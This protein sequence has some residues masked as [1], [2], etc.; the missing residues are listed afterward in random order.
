MAHDRT[1]TYSQLSAASVRRLVA[2]HYGLREPLSCKFY[3]L[4]LHDNYLVE[5]GGGKFIL[6]L[7]RNHWRSSEEI[8]F[9]LDLLA[10]LQERN[11]PIAAALRTVE[12][13]LAFRVESPEGERMAALFFYADG[14]SPA[15]SISPREGALLGRAIAQVHQLT[16]TFFTSY[17]RLALDLPY[18]LDASIDAVV[19]FI[20]SDARSYLYDLQEQLGAVLPGLPKEAGVYGICI[21]DVNPTNFHINPDD[22]ITLFDFDQCGYG[23]RAFEIGKFMASI[24]AHG[25]KRAIADA[26]L[27]GYQEERRLSRTEL[28]MIPYFEVLSVIWVM[29][30]HA[31]N[32]DR[33]GHKLLEKPFWDRRLAILRE[34]V[35]RCQA[36]PH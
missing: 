30:I 2:L 10:F 34:L 14:R 23:Y 27:G 26:F 13:E 7:Y 36:L 3:V 20:D 19:P 5:S 9:E 35:A 31:Y 32:V 12:G 25:E 8:G 17:R 28:D 22:R 29:A 15:N 24:H 33:I 4:G 11:G 6:R 16:A 1:Y 18:L 21:G